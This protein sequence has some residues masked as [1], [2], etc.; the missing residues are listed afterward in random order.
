MLLAVFEGCWTG[1]Y[2]ATWGSPVHGA[3]AKGADC[4]LGFT[5]TISDPGAHIWADRF[6]GYLKSG[7]T[8]YQA[9]LRAASGLFAYG[10]TGKKFEGNQYLTIHPARYG[11]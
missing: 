11:N 6:W 4:A 1:Y 2:N 8:A 7:D 9:W 3:V 10:V 5:S